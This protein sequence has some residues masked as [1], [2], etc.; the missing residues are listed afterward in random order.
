VVKIRLTRTGARNR[1]SYRI[2]VADARSP[3]DGRFIEEVGHYHPTEGG[4]F[5]IREERV[6][7]W[8]RQ[9]A[10]PTPTVKALLK[11]TEVWRKFVTS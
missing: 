5:K 7:Y 2:V 1:P 4:S 11:Q 10:K 3:R 8:L 6:L 9:G